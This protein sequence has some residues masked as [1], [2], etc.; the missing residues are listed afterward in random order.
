MKTV[1]RKVM[2]SI[3]KSHKEKLWSA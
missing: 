2:F 3:K 1:T